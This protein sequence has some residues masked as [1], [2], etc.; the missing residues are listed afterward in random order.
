MQT[1]FRAHTKQLTPESNNTSARSP[2]ANLPMCARPATRQG[3]SVT[4][5]TA[6]CDDCYVSMYC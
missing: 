1:V 5:A 3:F 6:S 4:V 2:L